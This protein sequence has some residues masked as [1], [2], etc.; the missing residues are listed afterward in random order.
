M[1]GGAAVAG[2]LAVFGLA[3]SPDVLNHW[4]LRRLIDQHN[5]AMARRSTLRLVPTFGASSVG[6]VA[7]GQ[8]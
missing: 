2:I 3:A 5:D 6:L 1:A 4:E 8:F 7:T